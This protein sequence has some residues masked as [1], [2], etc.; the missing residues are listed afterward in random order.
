MKTR[1]NLPGAVLDSQDALDAERIEDARSRFVEISGDLLAIA[2]FDGRLKWV[3]PAY[4]RATGL[5]RTELVGMPYLDLVHPEDRDTAIAQA[6]RLSARGGSAAYELRL[7]CHGDSH[8]WFLVTATVQEEEELVY[9]VAKDI[10]ERRRVEGEGTSFMELSLD[11]LAIGDFNGRFTRVNPAFERAT[12]YSAEHLAGEPYIDYFHPEDRERV[13]A[14]SRKLTE[15]GA[16]MRDFSA[17]LAC[18]DGSYRTILWSAAADVDE[19]LIFAVG[20]D[21]TGLAQSEDVLR[22]ADER[23][24]SVFDQAPIGM[25]LVSLEQEGA[26]V[27]LRVNQALCEITG[28]PEEKLIGKGFHSIAHPDDYDPNLHYVPWMQAGEVSVYEVEKRLIHAGGEPLWAQLT[29]SLVQDAHGRPLYLICQ[30]QDITKRKQAE[31][32]VVE[33]R[34][35]LQA[36]IDNTTAVICTK[37]REG[38]YRLVNRR[39]ETLHGVDREAVVGKT[40]HD[41]FPEELA[42]ARRSDDLQVLHSDL[43]LELEEVVPAENGPRTYLT[44]KFPLLDPARSMR[45]P[46]AVCAVSTDIT[47]RKRAEEALRASE[48]HFRQIVSTAH[49]AFVAIDASGVIT[50]WNPQAER[51]FGWSK[52]E[53]VGQSLAATIIPLRYREM[54]YRGLESFL[55]TGRGPL[56]DRRVEMEALHRDG[57]EFPVEMTVT[58]LRVNGEYFF[59]AFLHDISERKRAEAQIRQLAG[60]VESSA[61]AIVATTP[62]GTITAWN[63]GA[64]RQYGYSP[65]EAVGRPIS[66]L[67]PPDRPGEEEEILARA[68]AGHDI[69]QLET[70]GRRKDGHLV[71]VSLTVS[72]IRGQDGELVGV[73]YIARDISERKRAERALREV[74][75]G[76][77]AAFEDAPIG[78]ALETV[79]GDGDAR[80]LQVNRSLCEIT[81]FST[82]DLLGMTLE[83]IT[84]PDDREADREAATRLRAGEILNYRLEKRYL[85]KGGGVVWVMHSASTVH[86]TSGRLLYGIAQVE[87]ISERRNAQESLARAHGEL[88]R[89]AG[90]LERSNADLQQF[91]YAASHDLSEPLR[92]VSS[93]V[94]LLG[95]RYGGKLDSDADEFIGFA[96]DG[97]ARMQALIDGLLMYSRAGT[98]EYAIGPVDC[99]E[100]AE[101]T[102]IMLKA[103]IEEKDADVILETLPT[104]QGDAAQLAQ[105]FQNLIGNAIK[106]VPDRRPEVRVSS[107]RDGSGWHFTVSD[108]GIGIDSQHVE[109]IFSVFQRLHGRGEYPGSG[110]G[111]AIC[112]RIVERHGGR[113]WVESTP[114]EGSSFHFTILD[115][116]PTADNHEEEAPG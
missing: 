82:R 81:G 22:E 50:D 66:I 49:D 71:D 88:E 53:A 116:L 112:K 70:L 99:S 98:S 114:G 29:T 18:K 104:V 27:F 83:E 44:T 17:R 16:E 32:D 26:G 100:I 39:F 24:R 110:I 64:E 105:L 43:T 10:T 90:E 93:Y 57:H 20:R 21:E 36:I 102:L 97:V 101:A 42:E 2:G 61:D 41:L 3:N 8:R 87:D 38:R 45:T 91:A 46:Y 62:K 12:G 65:A 5:D 37:D 51:T 73:S 15:P 54:H 74:Q 31:R 34:E 111:L 89:R 67:D 63:R 103:S 79:D 19:G 84:H 92:M 48:E 94:Q 86:D 56:F 80:L 55:H 115:A 33:S 60:I 23:F 59:N 76:F 6:A 72:P 28:Y 7:R 9:T 25:A 108:N 1:P 47:E 106:F 14:E 75:E 113:I 13:F 96:V 4:E 109:R 35:R 78:V 85:R 69:T 52:Q 95:K 58:P 40:D 30:V 77:R 68:A 11:L 107:E